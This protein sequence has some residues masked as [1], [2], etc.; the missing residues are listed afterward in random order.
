MK[1]WKV[2]LSRVEYQ[3]GEIIVEAETEEEAREAAMEE[4]AE[5]YECVDSHEDILWCEEEVDDEEV[6]S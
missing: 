6:E 3:S 2:T 1:K 4:G 5:E